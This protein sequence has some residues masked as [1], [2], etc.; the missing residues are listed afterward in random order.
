MMRL[1][2]YPWS[3]AAILLC[4]GLASCNLN[5]APA[6]PTTDVNG[7]YTSV[8]STM[9][10]ELNDQLTQTAQA[11][12]SVEATSTPSE[13]ATPAALPSIQ[14][15]STLTP[16]GT[17][18]NPPVIPSVA[19]TSGI[20]SAT[21]AAPAASGST[22]VGCADSVFLQD[23]TIPDGT[24]EAPGVVFRKVWRMKN[25]GSC[26][27]GKE[28]KFGY[29]YGTKFG[30]GNLTVTLASGSVPP[31]GSK[32]FAINLTAPSTQNTYTGCWKLQTD[33]GY[34]FGQAACVTIKVSK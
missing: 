12:P 14:V 1:K 18:A 15:E 20:S 7:V 27:W 6:A 32:D 13:S 34:W 23:M 19:L 30:S 33:Q 4:L 2:K 17:N 29:A 21:A 11:V 31:G 28:F 22:A 9:I 8:A 3:S 25:T 24:V 16:S 5:K 10:V 26:E